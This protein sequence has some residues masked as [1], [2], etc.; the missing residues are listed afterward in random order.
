MPGRKN[1]RMRPPSPLLNPIQSISDINQSFLFSLP[2]ELWDVESLITCLLLRR[3]LILFNEGEVDVRRPDIH[4]KQHD[5]KTV[6]PYLRQVFDG[7][8][9]P[10]KSNRL[11][12]A[13]HRIDPR[14]QLNVDEPDRHT[15]V[16]KWV[17]RREKQGIIWEPMF[18]SASTRRRP[19][20]PK[21]AA[22]VDALIANNPT[23]RRDNKDSRLLKAASA[24]I[25]SRSAPTSRNPATPKGAPSTDVQNPRQADSAPPQ[26]PT[27]I[28]LVQSPTLATSEFLATPIDEEKKLEKQRLRGW[29]TRNELIDKQL[30]QAHERTSLALERALCPLSTDRGLLWL[31]MLTLHNSH[32]NQEPLTSAQLADAIPVAFPR[33]KTTLNTEFTQQI[34]EASVG[35]TLV[36]VGEAFARAMST[37]CYNDVYNPGQYV[38]QNMQQVHPN[39]DP[40]QENDAPRDGGEEAPEANNDDSSHLGEDGAGRDD[41]GQRRPVI[42]DVNKKQHHTDID[43]WTKENMNENE[44]KNVLLLHAVALRSSSRKPVVLQETHVNPSSCEPASFSRIKNNPSADSP[45]PLVDTRLNFEKSLAVRNPARAFITSRPGQHEIGAQDRSSRELNVVC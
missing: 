28:D 45:E 23:D 27:L 2:T 35:M 36:E 26:P 8:L 11:L 13:Y 3:L 15:K 9:P 4:P 31:Y 38:T 18:A 7:V 44:D 24:S 19:D 30:L 33:I 10:T 41:S 29:R 14:L 42:D 43:E 1:A 37:T 16:D 6:F 40:L 12:E 22:K 5:M 20:A 32:F 34:L 25:P 17:S 21:G 39:G